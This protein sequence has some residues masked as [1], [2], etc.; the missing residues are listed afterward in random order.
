M[1]LAMAALTTASIG[2][3]ELVIDGLVDE[4]EWQQAQVFNEFVV[5]QPFTRARAD[6][7]CEARMLGTPEGIAVAFVVTQPRDV[8][9][10]RAQTPRDADIPGDRVNLFIDFNADGVTAYNFTV[11]LS[12]AVQDA[13]LTNENQYS[14]D[15]DGEWQHA[16][17]EEEDR[18]TVE[19]LIPWSTAAM[20]DSKSETRTVAVIFDRVL[21]AN[22]QRS[23][24]AA[25][26]FT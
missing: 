24:S 4:P 18:W 23:A 26:S 16:V 21:G 15:W 9:R 10:Q 13:T 1:V 5:T 25:E 17:H 14:P 7:P 3:A 8:P 12:G 6:Y 11:G 20:H 19:M 2:H 22:S